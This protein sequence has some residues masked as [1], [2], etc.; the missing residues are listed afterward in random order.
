MQL[1]VARLCL[2][3]EEL[4]TENRCPR[5][6]SDSYAFLS[7]WLPSEE[8]RRWRKPLAEPARAESRFRALGQAIGRLFGSD[9]ANQLTLARR[10]SD[11]VPNL[12]FEERAETHMHEAPRKTADRT[13]PS[14]PRN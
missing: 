10:R 1:R 13:A 7:S 2:D 6:A 12:T 3:C 4:H 8:R 5:C 11:T 14:S 9:R